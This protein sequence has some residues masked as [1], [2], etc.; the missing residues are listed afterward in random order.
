VQCVAAGALRGA[1]DVRFPFLANVVAHWFIGFPIALALG[2]AL[3]GGAQGLWWGLTA[4]LVVVA[5]SLAL[6]FA[7][8]SKRALA[9]V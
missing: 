8:I 4:G 7:R 6:R 2:F 3:H 1:G 5:V 9:R